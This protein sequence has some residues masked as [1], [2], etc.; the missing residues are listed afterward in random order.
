MTSCDSFFD[1]VPHDQL[2]PST[3]WKSEDDAKQALT[4]CYN[5]WVDQNRGSSLC[6]YEDVMSDIGFNYT[7]TGNYAY[8]G[9]G[10]PTAAHAVNYYKYTAIHSVN[11]F[12]EHI[13]DVPFSDEALHIGDPRME[14]FPALLALWRRALDY[15]DL[16]DFRGSSVAEE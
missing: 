12:L 14:L 4:A 11:L 1:T 8:V 10:A 5:N 9:S 7:H 13:N 3:F 2:T 16:R 6:F 15:Q